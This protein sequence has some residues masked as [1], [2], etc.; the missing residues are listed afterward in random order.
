MAQVSE[1]HWGKL[2]VVHCGIDPEVFSPPAERD[3]AGVVNVLS[4]GRLVPFKGQGLLIEALAALAGRGI[5][6]RATVVGWG[7]NRRD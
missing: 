2:H 1:E 4:V 5:D 6:A 3:G 7:E